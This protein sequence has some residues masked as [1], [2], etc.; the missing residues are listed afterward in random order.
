M[1]QSDWNT[2]AKSNLRPEDIP[3]NSVNFY[4]DKGWISWGDW[5]GTGYV[6]NQGRIY[7]S[8]NEARVFVHSLE[9][10]TQIEWDVWSKSSARPSNIP[11]GP[12]TVYINDGWAGWGDWLGTDRIANQDIVFLPF[13]EARAFVRSLEIKIEL[14]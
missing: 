2:W 10:K 1:K 14:E 13:E 9:I 12:A 7:L 5:L 11:A 4:K 8:F 3:S 6:A